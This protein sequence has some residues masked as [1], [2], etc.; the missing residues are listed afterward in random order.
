MF[1]DSHPIKVTSRRSRYSVTYILMCTCT[2]GELGENHF[3]RGRILYIDSEK[4]IWTLH[5]H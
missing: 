5:L 1:Y 3:L 2:T 4:S